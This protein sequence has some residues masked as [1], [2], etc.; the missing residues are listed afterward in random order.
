MEKLSIFNPATGALI[1][2]VPADNAASVA[3]KAAQARAA[4]PR[5]SATPLADRK[6]C[7]ARFRG[8]LLERIETLAHTLSSEV[9]KPIK[10]SRNEINGLLGRIDFFLEHRAHCER[11]RA[12]Q[13]KRN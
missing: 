11:F 10:Q 5:W 1:V 6:A 12:R 8:L 2:E 13:Q 3:D 9:G 4:Q 7:I